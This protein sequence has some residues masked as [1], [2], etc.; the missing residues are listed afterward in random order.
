MVAKVRAPAVASAG[1][2]SAALATGRV[3]GGAIVEV[4]LTPDGSPARN[5]AFDVTPARLVTGIVTERGVCTASAEG[6]RALYPDLA[7]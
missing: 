3:A 4:Q 5:D 6:L 1:P 2:A 7:L